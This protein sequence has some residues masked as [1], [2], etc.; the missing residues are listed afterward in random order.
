M[1]FCGEPSSLALGRIGIGA[2]YFMAGG[3]RA[4]K[5]AR[6]NASA[7]CTP[8]CYPKFFRDLNYGLLRQQSCYVMF[9]VL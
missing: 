9:T 7:F 2:L 1:K 8:P 4:H 6:A 3:R 5:P